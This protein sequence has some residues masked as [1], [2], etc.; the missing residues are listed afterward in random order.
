V[1]N[2]ESVLALEP[3][4]RTILF[5]K[6]GIQC[7]RV[8]PIGIVLCGA[9]SASEDARWICEDPLAVESD[10]VEPIVMINDDGGGGGGDDDGDNG[11]DSGDSGVG[12]IDD[13]DT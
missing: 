4:E 13:G 2:E 9:L 6:R 1:W 3:F 7:A 11:D 12:I 10:I 5:T 8:H